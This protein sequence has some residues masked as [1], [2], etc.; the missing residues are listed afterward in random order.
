MPLR[1]STA[2]EIPAW[3]RRLP[4]LLLSAALMLSA[5]AGLWLYRIQQRF[6]GVVAW[7]T[8]TYQVLRALDTTMTAI[9]EVDSTQRG[10]LVTG[11]AKYLKA[12]VDARLSFTDQVAGIRSLVGDNPAQL[13]S[14]GALERLESERLDTEDRVIQARDAR[15]EGAVLQAIHEGT[16]RGGMVEIR[17]VHQRMVDEELRLLRIRE[18]AVLEGQVAT[19]RGMGAL[20]MAALF[21]VALGIATLVRLGRERASLETA[22]R[23][24]TA[25]L[26]RTPDFVATA[27]PD[28]RLTYLNPA[29]RELLGLGG[30]SNLAE[31]TLARTHTEAAARR[32]EEEAL[33]SAEREGLWNGESAFRDDR[34]RTVPVSLVILGHHDRAGRMAGFSCIARDI[35]AQKATERLKNDFISTVNHELRTPLTSIKGSLGLLLAGPAGALPEAAARMVEIAHRNAERLSRIIDDILDLEKLQAEGLDF[36]LQDLE[37]DPLLA[38]SAEALGPFFLERGV[39]LQPPSVPGGWKLRVDEGRFLQVLANLLSNAAKFSP[40]DATVIFRAFAGDPGWVRLEVENGGPGIPD[41]FRARIFQPFS[42][43][44]PPTG[45]RQGTGLGLSIAKRI[46]ER[47]GGRIGFESEPGRTVFWVELPFVE[48]GR[49]EP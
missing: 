21:C 33:P 3:R 48:A 28:G 29:L 1:P 9:Q 26:D 43:A 14:L 13:A 23:R 22:W 38:Q 42:Q 40:K 19:S 6:A 45:E 25:I 44:E 8:H 7:Q 37:L 30:G 18:K 36:Q 39:H 5:G 31:W 47:L 17:A 35:Q 46:T 34:G 10:Y 32:L 12:H 20:A 2:L 49:L 11:D 15:G 24:S 27:D 16:G 4:I 41:A